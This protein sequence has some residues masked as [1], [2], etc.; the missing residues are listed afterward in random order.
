MER[1]RLRKLKKKWRCPMSNNTFKLPE[2]ETQLLALLTRDKTFFEKNGPLVKEEYFELQFHK[3]IFRIVR[4]FWEKYEE[5]MSFE[6]GKIQ[7]GY[8]FK[9]TLKKDISIEEYF[10]VLQNLYQVDIAGQK[11]IEDHL[12]EFVQNAETINVLGKVVDRVQKGKNPL[13]VEMDGREVPVAEYFEKIK[14]IGAKNEDDG[15]GED[16]CSL[17]ERNIEEPEYI[18]NPFI[19]PGEKGYL[20]AGYK[21][22]KTFM[23][24]QLCYCLGKGLDFLGFEVPKPRQVLYIRFELTDYEIQRRLRSMNTWE[25]KSTFEKLPWLILKKGFNLTG[26]DEKD[27][28]WLFKQIDKHQPDLLIFDPLYKLTNENIAE[29][30]SA[31][32]LLRAYEKIQI[33]YSK[34]SILTAHHMVK[35]T[36]DKRDGDSW[37]SSYGPM[38]FF[39]DMDYEMRLRRIG[40]E[41]PERFKLDFLT[42]SKAVDK[43]E[44]ERDEDTLIYKV[45]TESKL[46]KKTHED[47]TKLEAMAKILRREYGKTYQPLN[48]TIFKKLCADELDIGWSLFDRLAKENNGIFWN[49]EKLKAWGNPIVFEPIENL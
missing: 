36:G 4:R 3:D 49:A 9:S 37:D 34:L 11:A 45:V 33:K 21:V 41:K 47:Q 17:L 19:K 42:N 32:P 20:T 38:Q 31:I 7:L 43:M 16:I 14:G 15:K 30:K 44:L 23:I 2:F 6:N 40:N 18:V 22:G 8:F 25:W 13:Y 5:P 24:L 12:I 10:N 27:L 48:Q 1:K 46:Q 35:L 29:P 26:K 39:A 28:Q